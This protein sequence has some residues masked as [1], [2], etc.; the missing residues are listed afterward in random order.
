LS[1]RAF[2]VSTVSDGAVGRSAV[3]V[4]NGA[5]RYTANA[6]AAQLGGLRVDTL[7]SSESTA[8]DIVVR[9]GS[10]FRGLAT[11]LAR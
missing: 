6:L 4:R 2:I 7:P 9:V 5:K 3:L 11:D 8:A 1:E 10:D